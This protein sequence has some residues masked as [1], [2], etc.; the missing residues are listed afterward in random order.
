MTIFACAGYGLA[1]KLEQCHSFA[2]ARMN[3]ASS[4]SN[5]PCPERFGTDHVQ[6]PYSIVRSL[7]QLGLADWTATLLH[8]LGRF[9][10]LEAHL[11]E[12]DCDPSR[13]DPACCVRDVLLSHV[14]RWPEL[15]PGQRLEPA[16][17][18]QRITAIT[19][20]L[21]ELEFV[22]AVGEWCGQKRFWN[23]LNEDWLYFVTLGPEPD[24]PKLERGGNEAGELL[25][26][27]LDPDAASH[28]RSVFRQQL[29]GEAAGERA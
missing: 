11:D 12:C 28:R 5:F 22:G 25:D 13:L 2:T 27:W 26:A 18:G 1:A 9:D 20:D 21:L 15:V 7:M 29:T 4:Q 23:P 8:W 24:E 3:T 17:R 14:A 10:G 6:A 16:Q 19:D